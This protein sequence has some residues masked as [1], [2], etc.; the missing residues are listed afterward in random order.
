MKI[1]RGRP[2]APICCCVLPCTVAAS[3]DRGASRG[4]DLTAEEIGQDRPTGDD[5]PTW[6]RAIAL[7][8][9]ISILIGT[10]LIWT[11]SVAL[12]PAIT[13]VFMACYGGVLVLAILA[14]VAATGRV[15]LGVDAAILVLAIVHVLAAYVVHPLPGDEGALT[16]RAASSL[17]GGQHVYGVAYPEVFTQPGVGLTKTMD[18]GGDYTYAYPPLAAIL[19]ALT[20]KVV[21]VLGDYPNLA[22]TAMTTGALI[23]GAVLLWLLLPRGWQS[24]ATT[25][26]LGYPLLPPYAALGYPAVVAMA[27]LIPVV[28]AWPTTGAGGRIG[29]GGVVRAILLGTA[30]A[31][32][33]LAWFLVPFLLV[34]V[35]AVRRAELPARRALLV[36]GAFAGL[37]AAAFL[38]LNLYFIVRDRE[39]WLVGILTPMIQHAVPHGQGL[40]DISY[41]L[42]QGSGALDFYS[43]ATLLF[44]AALLVASVVFIRTLGPALTV[45]PWAVFYL[46]IRSQ[47]GYYLLMTPLWLAAAVTVARGMFATA[48]QP[49][50]PRLSTSRRRVAAGGLLFVPTVLCLAVAIGTPAPLRMQI[51]SADAHAA[52]N[53]GVWRLQ[54]RVENQSR[55]GLVPNFAVS[56]NQSMS[57]YWRKQDGP[58]VLAPNQT[59]TYTLV[60]ANPR[61]YNPGAYGFWKLRA[62]TDRPQTLST[63]AIPTSPAARVAS[64]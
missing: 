59:A 64:P 25:V 63:V 38:A 41:Y 19:T 28:V 35:F 32:H 39:Q 21:P 16:A 42:V 6:H 13:L 57:G 30:C 45:L 7:L 14:L 22:A 17:L 15:M 2:L 29:R 56:A 33:Q 53:R 46:S 26:M 34:G 43:Y 10:R 5:V 11:D 61:G 44:A 55:N 40:I 20:M 48:W 51:L 49:R 54:V 60:A 62:V 1:E 47:D 23:A 12:S 31:A 50:L 27:L 37:A 52:N 8:A 3:T 58:P 36:V 4:C 9:V 24:A 18:G